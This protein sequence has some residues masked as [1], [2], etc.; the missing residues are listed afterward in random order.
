MI[1]S[2][3]AAYARISQRVWLQDRTA[4]VGASEV[5][6]CARRVFFGK[7]EADPVYGVARNLDHIDGWGARTRGSV[8]EDAFW[9]PAVRAAWGERALFVGSEQR[10]FVDGFL[11]ATPDGLLIDQPA[12]A[13]AHLGVADIGGDSILLDCKTVDPRTRLDEPKPEHIFQ[14][15]AGMGLVRALTNYRPG[16]ALLS[17]SDASFWDEGREFAVPFDEAVF[18]EAQRRARDVMLAT[19]AQALRP[20]GVIA[21]GRE[22]ERC[23]FTAACGQARA[24]RVPDG[25]TAADPVLADTVADLARRARAA[26]DMA[27]AAS[28]EA[29][30]IEHEVRDLLAA[31]GTRRLS[32]EGVEVRWSP[33]KGRPSYDMKGIREA[34]VAAGVD[35]ARFERVGDPTDRLAITLSEIP[36]PAGS[37]AA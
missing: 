13:L 6:Q 8:F 28:N 14:V 33:V 12:D 21:G 16:I 7:N 23:P 15:V 35:L 17:Y 32:H 36:A 4:T 22:C 25:A 26:K 24:D 31:A 27:E 5:G 29:R 30:E 9:A 2:A 20:E 18:A 10:S 1:R 37:P 3:L 11:S 19:S 34:A